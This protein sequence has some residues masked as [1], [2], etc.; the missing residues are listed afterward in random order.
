MVRNGRAEGADRDRPRPPRLRLGRQPEPRDRG[1][2]RRLG[3]RV[4]L[5]AAERAAQHR[6]RRDLGVAPPRRRRRHGLLAARRR[7]DRL[8]RHARRPTRASRACCGTIP[9]PA[10]CATPTR[11]TTEAIECAR[12]NGLDLPMLAHEDGGHD[13]RSSHARL[14]LADA[15]R[16]PG[17]S[18]SPSQVARRGAARIAALEPAGRRRS[19]RGGKRVLRHQHRLRPARAGAH[20]RRTSWTRLQDEPRALARR[21]RRR[22]CW[23]SASCGWCWRSR[24]PRSRA[25]ARACAPTRGRAAARC[26]NA[27]RLSRASRRRARSAPPAISRRSRTCRCVLLGVGEARVTA[28]CCPPPP[29]SPP[30][31]SN[32]WRSAPKE[33][34]ALLNGTQVSTALALDGAVRAPSMCSPRRS[35]PA[36]CR[37]TRSRAATR[38]STRASTR[39]RGHAGPDRG[40]R[41]C[42]ASCMA[43]SEIRASHLE[44]DARA[45]SVFAALPAAGRWARAS[46]CSRTPRACWRS[47]RTPSPTTR[48]CSPDTRRVLSGGN[49]HAEPVAFAA[50][51][52]ALAIAEIGALSERRIALLIDAHLSGLP[53]FLVADGGLNSGFMIAQVTAAALA[54]REQVARTSGERRQPADLGQPGRSR[55][56]GDLRRAAAARHGRQ[57]RRASSRSSCWPRR[58]ASSSTVR[59]ES[60]PRAGSGAGRDPA[61]VAAL[62]GRPLV[63]RRHRGGGGPGRRRPLSRAAAAVLPSGAAHR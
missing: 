17:S 4:R 53:P 51:Y 41:A 28:S 7:G 20:R 38:R 54:S 13:A 26:S 24:S 56:D 16:A 35:S 47:R 50:D 33:G 19:S 36:R 59:S 21:R 63:V 8:R 3:R 15:A 9:A 11:A 10:S 57:Q 39:V 14:S 52:L 45:G 40:G 58:R 31:V 29:R 62:H 25:A 2:A 55:V 44:C 5:A 46:T 6:E 32:R 23:T 48:W 12:E 18:P 1:D 34:L 22:R 49:F 37:S 27:R 61:R 43:G 60:S 30:R 42:C